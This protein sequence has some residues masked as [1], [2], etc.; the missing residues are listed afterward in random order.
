MA[1]GGWFSP[2]PHTVHTFDVL[3]S[4]AEDGRGIYGCSFRGRPCS[5]TEIRAF[6][7]PSPFAMAHAEKQRAKR[8]RD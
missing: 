6:G 4:R 3:V 2:P 7:S 1:K 8:R 5:A